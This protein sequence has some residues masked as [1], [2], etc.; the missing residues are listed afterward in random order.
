MPEWRI[1]PGVEAYEASNEGQIRRIGRTRIRKQILTWN[2][3]L[4]IG[5][6]VDGKSR[7]LLVNRLVCAAFHGP[8][9]EGDVH[10]AH[11]DGDKCNNRPSNLSW[12]TRKEN[13]ADKIR[14]GRTI[15]GN[16]HPGRK[17]SAERVQEIRAR[18]AALPRGPSGWCVKKGMTRALAAEFG[19]HQ[20]TLHQIIRGDTW[21][22]DKE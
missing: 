20:Y 1:I 15:R 21:N 18:H 19:I 4:K 3:Y 9:P 13:E 14:H 8:P 16:R 11:E 17:M 7:T 12:K 10:A 6:I 2:G 22:Y 5:I